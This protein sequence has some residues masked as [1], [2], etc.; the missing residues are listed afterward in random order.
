MTVRI[1]PG[2]C[3]SSASTTNH[4]LQVWCDNAALRRR[5]VLER[6]VRIAGR[7]DLTTPQQLL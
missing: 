6:A 5:A 1:G 2:R 7:F 4:F 3:A